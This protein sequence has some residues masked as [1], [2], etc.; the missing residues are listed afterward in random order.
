MRNDAHVS[1]DF[2]ECMKFLVGNSVGVIQ[3]SGLK[4]EVC[5]VEVSEFPIA[6]L[7]EALIWA[8]RG[9]VAFDPRMVHGL[10]CA[11][12]FGITQIEYVVDKF[13]AISAN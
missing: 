6:L 4:E 8:H 7:Q 11:H 10:S 12:S 13:A 3:Q 1:K 9:S 2:V 5:Q